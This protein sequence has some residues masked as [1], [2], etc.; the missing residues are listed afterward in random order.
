MTIA[1][2]TNLALVVHGALC[3]VATTAYIKYGDRKVLFDKLPQESRRLMQAIKDE[4]TT[5]LWAQ[6]RPIVRDSAKVR[7]SILKPDGD[8]YVEELADVT[9]GE[10]YY[11]AIRDFVTNSSGSLVDYSL[12]LKAVKAW[13]VWAHRLSWFILILVILEV[14]ILGLALLV[15]VSSINEADSAPMWSLLLGSVPTALVIVGIFICLILV[16]VKQGTIVDLKLN[17]DTNS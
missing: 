5:D 3:L 16:H 12:I 1:E 8:D 4:I 17:Y 7:T 14:A 6:L 15:I 2:A 13:R 9:E 10:G 11:Q